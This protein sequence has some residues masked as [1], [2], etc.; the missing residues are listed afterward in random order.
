MIKYI[1]AFIILIHGLIHFMGFARGFGFWQYYSATKDISKLTGFLWFVTAMLLVTTSVLLLLKRESWPYIA[2]VAAILSQVLIITSWNDAK[3]GT[4]ANIIILL[5]ATAAW[6]SQQFESAFIKDVKANLQR[7]NTI[8]TSL[9]TEADIQPLPQ[10][11]QKYLRYCGVINQPKVK[12]LR[13]VFEGEMRNKGKDWFKFRSLQYNFFEEPARLFFM[14]GKMFGVTV[15][16]YHHYMKANAV[17]DIRLFGLFS[18][19]KKS[20]DVM[21]Q[22]ETVTLFNDMC[23]LVPATLIDKRIQWETVDSLSTKAIFTNGINKITALLYF[24][25]K[26]QLINFISDDRTAVSDMKQ[27]R[28]STPV[29]EYQH[30]NGRNIPTHGEAVWHYP[31]VEFIYGKFNLKSIDYNVTDFKK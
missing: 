28:F 27:Y 19:V 15:P 17:M 20:G 3:F 18:I 25:E 29:K 21:N 5:V 16:G 4:I 9:L 31:N 11:V 8:Q 6:G 2:I 26:G 23:L 1:F 12:N 7:T 14:K 30:I 22:T 13:I 24:N 10:P